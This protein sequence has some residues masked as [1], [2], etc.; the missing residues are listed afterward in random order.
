MKKVHILTLL[1]LLWATGICQDQRMK[2]SLRTLIKTT[3]VDTAR[4][5]ALVDLSYYESQSSIRLELAYKALYLSKQRKWPLGE[6]S[7]YIQLTNCYRNIADH[8]NALDNALKALKK[9]EE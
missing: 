6:A 9:Y 4:V 7:A 2:D 5:L 1:I 3:T 8:S